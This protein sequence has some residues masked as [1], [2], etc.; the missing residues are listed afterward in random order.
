[1]Q[2]NVFSNLLYKW[3]VIKENNTSFAYILKQLQYQSIAVYGTNELTERCINELNMF[4][5]KVVNTNDIRQ[6]EEYDCIIIIDFLNYYKL[7]KLMP[8]HADIFS[9]RNLIELTYFLCVDAKKISSLNSKTKKYIVRLP[10]FD[11]EF[12]SKN[13]Y[14]S[15]A[16]SLPVNLDMLIQN[17][18][19][20]KYL[21]NDVAEYSDEYIKQVF[22]IP[23]I[24]SKDNGELTNVEHRSDYM[25]II[26][27][28]RYTPNQPEKY[29]NRIFFFGNCYAFGGGLMIVELFQVLYK[30]IF[31]KAKLL[32]MA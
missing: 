4:F 19:Y 13:I 10:R 2:N 5:T 1:M 21:Y 25:N 9:I 17:P 6:L 3:L 15:L 23:A 8:V 32:I 28:E 14:E 27:G 18:E 11:V 12:N 7:K 29:Y 26:N 31:Q 20:F 22:Q 30:I 24:I 16:S